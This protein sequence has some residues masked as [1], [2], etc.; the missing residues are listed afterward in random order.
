MVQ[1]ADLCQYLKLP[2]LKGG[3]RQLITAPASEAFRDYQRILA[4]RITEIEQRTRR[5]QKGDDILLSVITDGRHAAIDM[6]L[7]WP[8]NDNEPE[9]KLNR[10]VANV[11]RIYQETGQNLYCRPDGTAF[12]QPGA[13]AAHLLGP[14]HPQR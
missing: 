5:V 8:G 12:P 7:V 9:N 4:E 1:K 11:H 3:Q 14:R 6:R 10:L 13:G 2:A